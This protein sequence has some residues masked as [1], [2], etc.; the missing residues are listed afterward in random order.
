MEYIAAAL[1][2]L[3]AI[4]V[5]MCLVNWLRSKKQANYLIFRKR[6]P[7]LGKRLKRPLFDR[8]RGKVIPF[9]ANAS[10]R[11]SHRQSDSWQNKK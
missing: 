7:A 5:A 8:N 2:L 10:I 4:C 6:K 3:I 9:P 11:H 1:I